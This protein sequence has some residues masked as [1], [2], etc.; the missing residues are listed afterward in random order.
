MKK[1]PHLTNTILERFYKAPIR[2]ISL[3]HS[4][5]LLNDKVVVRVM[6]SWKDLVCLEM[7][8][9]LI[10]S[11][12]AWAKCLKKWKRLQEFSLLKSND[13]SKSIFDEEYLGHLAKCKS[14]TS[15]DLGEFEKMG[16]NMKEDDDRLIPIPPNDMFQKWNGLHLKHFRWQMS[17]SSIDQKTLKV[18]C[19]W[20]LTSLHLNGDGDEY[21]FEDYG[22][23]MISKIKTLEKL[24]TPEWNGCFWAG[25]GLEHLQ[26]LQHLTHLTVELAVD[27][28]EH[29]FQDLT[30]LAHLRELRINLQLDFGQKIDDL[31]DA[32][33]SQLEILFLGGIRSWENGNEN[34]W[35]KLSN[36]TQIELGGINKISTSLIRSL[37]M[38]PFLQRLTR[39]HI[40]FY[41][42]V[43]P[44]SSLLTGKKSFECF[45]LLSS[46]VFFVQ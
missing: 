13:I 32:L 33:P 41:F 37:E 29:H 14:L 39:F 18:I 40:D 38:A 11:E 35:Q 26:Q 6:S 16:E 10:I 43:C 8:P 46:F 17:G 25:T 1:V 22:F 27:F 28:H 24:D 21:V 23:E 15:L 2:K 30:R 42:L 20:P 4:R 3:T 19:G 7:H 45:F 5:R 31:I 36:L 34:V 9:N 12:E 44:I